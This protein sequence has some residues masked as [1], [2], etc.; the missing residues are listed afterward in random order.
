LFYQLF[1]KPLMR[2]IL[3]L[4]SFLSLLLISQSGI[5]QNRNIF[6]L[7]NRVGIGPNNGIVPNPQDLLH[8]HGWN[9]GGSVPAVY[10]DPILRISLEEAMGPLATVDPS[11]A[12]GQ[13][14]IQS[15]TTKMLSSIAKPYDFVLSTSAEL[16]SNWYPPANPMQ[17]HTGDLILSSRNPKGAMRFTTTTPLFD[18]NGSIQPIIGPG[19][20]ERMT[21]LNNGNVGVG[22][23]NPIFSVTSA[24]LPILTAFQVGNISIQP[25][26]FSGQNPTWGS[27][28]YNNFWDHITN[29]P[30]RLEAGSANGLVFEP[31]HLTNIDGSA[32]LFSSPN[33][34]K[35]A[36]IA[37][38]TRLLIQPDRWYADMWKNSAYHKVF[39]YDLPTWNP[40]GINMNFDGALSIR[41]NVGMGV[42]N[43]IYRNGN[44]QPLPIKSP[45]QVG[46]VSIQPVTFGTGGTWGSI[47]YNNFWDPTVPGPKRLDDGSV[48]GLVFHPGVAN[49]DDGGV[50]L[51][52]N[53][54][55]LSGTNPGAETNKLSGIFEINPEK[56]RLYTS[57]WKTTPDNHT[58]WNDLM[59]YTFPQASNNNNGTLY[60]QD[61][62]YIGAREMVAGVHPPFAE[63]GF[64]KLAVKG[65]ILASEI[66]VDGRP[67]MWPDFVFATGYDLMP[68]NKLESHIRSEHHLP[69][70]PSAEE[71]GKTGIVIG[72]L[73]SKLLQKIEELTLYVIQL[74]NENTGLE[75]RI[76]TLETK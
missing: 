19:D 36:P 26:E 32:Y 37:S 57:M 47:T 21:I 53:P 60:I 1:L 2:H 71:V 14:G 49:E 42:M 61:K 72:D 31:S 63:N 51:F 58:E 8:I 11:R 17:L 54:Y 38:G 68:L 23:M 73:Q 25:N 7:N 39:D 56:M 34:G 48:S 41:D 76:E 3:S 43:P 13:L 16:V 30:K 40:D 9:A 59:I 5:G 74:K 52:A 67:E 29:T 24:P 22:T 15:T 50:Y 18:P 20:L 33:G 10:Y 45:L 69:N 62:V 55:A 44:L 12:Y 28:A 6:P 66:V 75:Q 4:L 27:I 70:I 35:N 64:Y 46:N 65:S